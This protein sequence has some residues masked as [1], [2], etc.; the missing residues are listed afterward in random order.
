MRLLILVGFLSACQPSKAEVR[1]QVDETAPGVAVEAV[2]K[3]FANASN[4]Q[5]AVDSL[6]RKS[7][8]SHE[9]TGLMTCTFTIDECEAVKA[10]AIK[11]GQSTAEELANP[12]YL[13]AF[14]RG[15]GDLDKKCGVSIQV[16][17]D[18]DDGIVTVDGLDC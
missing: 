11:S 12:V 2:K 1:A 13:E 8:G 7:E 16:T 17:H 4:V 9:F 18:G 6:V 5:C 15:L 10:F 3:Q 14:C